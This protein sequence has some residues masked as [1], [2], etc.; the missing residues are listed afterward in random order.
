MF[1]TISRLRQGY[2]ERLTFSSYETLLEVFDS[3]FA[4]QGDEM[5]AL[6]PNDSFSQS[7]PN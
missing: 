7:K 5:T 1:L 4:L 2:A 6:Q 3:R